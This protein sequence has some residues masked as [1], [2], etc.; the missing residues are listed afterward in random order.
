MRVISRNI[1]K[2]PKTDK[3]FVF[4]FGKDESAKIQIDECKEF[5]WDKYRGKIGF[6]QIGQTKEG[7]VMTVHCSPLKS[8]LKTKEIA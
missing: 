5:I 6:I 8:L 2:L 3:T 4:K 1:V 7:W